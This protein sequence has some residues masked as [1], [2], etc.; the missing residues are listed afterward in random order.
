MAFYECKELTS[1]DIPKSVESIF[2][3]YVF[4]SCD[5]LNSI[6]VAGDNSYLASIEGILYN[7]EISILIQCPS[8]KD[9]VSIP[10]SV[11]T[12][13]DNAFMY[14]KNLASVEIPNSVI[15]IRN[16]AFFSCEKLTI[17]SIP[18]SVTTIGPGA[19]SECINMNSITVAGDNSHYA[20]LDGVLYNK[21]LSILIQC[22]GK[23]ESVEIPGSVTSIGDYSFSYSSIK[24]L[25]IP[26][27]VT[28]IGVGAFSRCSGLTSVKLPDFIT[29]IEAS[30]FQSCDALTSVIIPES[31][32]KIESSAFLGCRALT[33]AV[34]PNSVTEIG[35]S[36]F[37]G[38]SALTSLELPASVS[39]IEAKAFYSCEGLESIICHNKIL[40]AASPNIFYGV[41]RGI[42][43]YVPEESIDDY[44]NATQWN[45]F[46]NILP[47]SA[48][49]IF[50]ESLAEFMVYPNPVTEILN[51]KGMEPESLVNIYNS[52]G[53]LLYSSISVNENKSID[54][55][56]FTAGTY[57]L[58]V[59]NG[60]TANVVRILK[61]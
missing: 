37:F 55:S 41:P 39:I 35:H 11:T 5:N 44:K 52:E 23:K 21:E 24:S 48:V 8:K 20:S 26:N 32:T 17:V 25:I 12:I 7:K 4:T 10:N 46:N 1:V 29:I 50:T 16:G 34:I 14:S 2:G 59:I 42:P 15:T 45:L 27:S 19:F 3:D 36:A 51:I 56:R 13:R 47:L 58:K 6:T 30:T 22:P 31:V 43:L 18:A 40:P 57:L 53:R 61:E 49:N 9:S 33:S 60:K 38:C 54:M 28:N